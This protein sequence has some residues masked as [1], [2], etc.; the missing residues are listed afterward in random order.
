MAEG[1]GPFDLN[2]QQFLVLY[3]VL[4]V[5]TVIIGAAIP[6][7]LKPEGRDGPLTDAD[8]AAYLAGGDARLAEAVVARLLDARAA[9]LVDKELV[10]REAQA[11]RTRTELAVLRL[12]SPAPWT[13][14]SGALHEPAK[15]I[16]AR[17]EERGLLIPPGEVSQIRLYQTMPYLLLMFFGALKVA[18][19]LSRD[20]PVSILVVLLICTAIGALARFSV[21]DRSTRAGKRAL[22]EA[23]EREGRLK[24]APASGETGMAVALFGTSVLVGSDLWDFHRMR[25]AASSGGGDSGSSDSGSGC[26]G[27]GGGCGG[28]S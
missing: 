20:K 25:A 19:G 12:S 23:L 15:A 11:G 7:W 22:D 6:R 18:I 1:L 28:C 14:V 9:T 10:I 3:L 2:G 21:I 13:A 4:A 16:R 8:Q 17:L 24:L 27:G 26:G 5:V